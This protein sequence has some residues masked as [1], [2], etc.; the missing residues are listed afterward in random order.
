M[1]MNF[2]GWEIHVKYKKITTNHKEQISQVDDFSTLYGKIQDSGVIEIFP[3]IC[4][5][6]SWGPFIKGQSAA[7]WFSS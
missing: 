2:F 5:E 7:S 1:Y 3:E 6:L 4:I